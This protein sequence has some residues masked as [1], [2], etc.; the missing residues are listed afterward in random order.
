MSIVGLH[1][2]THSFKAVELEK[3]RGKPVLKKFGMYENP[4][5]SFGEQDPDK[6]ADYAEALA[7]FF[8]E[9]GFDTANVVVSLP[10][11]EVFVRTI[12]V[13]HMS[14]KDLQK[15][16]QFEAEQY[17]PLPIKEVSLSYQILE[18]TGTDRN[19]MDVLLVAAKNTIVQR[20]IAVL[21]KAGLIT[22]ALE[23]ET[24][25]MAR[26][27]KDAFSAEVA[28]SVIVSVNTA[29][30]LIVI[31]YKGAVRLTR[32]IPIGGEAITRAVS[33]QLSLDFLQAEEYK[34]TY[35]LDGTK[36]DGKVF[37]AIRSVFDNIL[38]EIKRSEIAFTTHVPN[39]I[40]KRVLVAGGTA[41]MPGLLAYMVHNLDVEVELAHPWEG[42]S[43]S[44]KLES[45][46]ESLL[47]LG[48]LLAVPVGLA[49]KEVL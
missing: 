36:M 6:H 30:T 46:K 21:K 38:S 20:Y 19:K 15:A 35:G 18:P 39:A 9:V 17:I 4:D 37:E 7:D 43:L 23:P 49:L 26:S 29:N 48:P 3:G 31:T 22:L 34:K 11:H 41:L 24:I 5:I 25:S 44:P 1:L 28:A 12:Q 45:Q 16:I 33:Q 40:I 32:S 2:G 27:L 47:K 14:D 10:E 13:P 8:S 42:V